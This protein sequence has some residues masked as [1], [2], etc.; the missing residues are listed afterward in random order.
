MK[1][2]ATN[3]GRQIE[4]KK[5]SFRV[6]GGAPAN[7]AKCR[8]AIARRRHVA[9][10]TAIATGVGFFALA[11]SAVRARGLN[12]LVRLSLRASAA[13]ISLGLPMLIP[14]CRSTIRLNAA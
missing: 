10:A 11:L 14:D 9:S 12:D 13:G 7:D 6:A 1:L 4:K 3:Q 2:H 5:H 8:I